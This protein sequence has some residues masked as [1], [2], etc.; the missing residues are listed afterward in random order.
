METE[1]NRQGFYIFIPKP[2]LFRLGIKQEAELE[3]KVCIT[4]LYCTVVVYG[5]PPINANIVLF[6]TVMEPWAGRQ[7]DGCSHSRARLST[8]T[9][10]ES[11]PND[12]AARS[13]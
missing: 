2:T 10:N 1:W 5:L 8:D 4:P 9:G 13:Q 11:S 7:R 3:T 12:Y 6:Q